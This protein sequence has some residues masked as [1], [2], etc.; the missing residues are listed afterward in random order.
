MGML[1]GHKAIVTGGASGIGRATCRRM[2]Q[3]GASVAVLDVNG[4]LAEAVANDIDGRA[5]Q[6]DVADADDVHRVVEEAAGALGGISVMFNNAGVGGFSPIH[7]YP[8]DEW[9]QVV[10]VSLYGAFHGIRAAASHMLEHGDGRVVNTASISGIRPAAG[11]AA[12][13]AA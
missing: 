7:D 11:E 6:V 1:D 10:R 4:D 9:D 3:E 2:A 13:S 12:Y 8:L 5:Y